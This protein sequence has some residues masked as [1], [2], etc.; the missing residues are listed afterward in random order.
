MALAA[1]PSTRSETVNIA[2][3]LPELAKR[4]GEETAIIDAKHDRKGSSAKKAKITFAELEAQTNR[5]ANALVEAGITRGMR[6]MLMVM[7]SVLV[8]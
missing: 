4:L 1:E 8:H 7:V 6:T 2:H 3:Y 5:V